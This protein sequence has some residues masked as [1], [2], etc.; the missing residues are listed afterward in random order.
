M[1]TRRI[2]IDAQSGDFGAKVIIRGVIE[3]Q[4]CAAYPFIA[5]LCGDS[6]EI[7]RV[8]DELEGEFSFDRSKYIVEHCTEKISSLENRSRVWRTHSNSSIIRCITLQKERVVDASVS[9]GDS[10][11]LIGA[12]QFLLGRSENVK[13]PAL[14]ALIPTA[15]KKPVLLLDVGANLNCRAEHLVSFASMGS[16]YMKR[17]FDLKAPAVSLLNIGKESSKGPVCIQDAAK[18]LLQH[19][20]VNYEGYI[21]GNRVLSGDADVVVCD[22]FSGNVLLKASESFYS[23]TASVLKQDPE[24]L[25]KLVRKMEALNP[26]N[27]GAV[28]F[29]GIKGT[30]LKA[31]GGSSSQA[32]RNA[33]LTALKTVESDNA[34]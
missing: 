14:A 30:V 34:H 23:L 24:L 15:G 26:E 25:G 17:L 7:C 12:A 19:R 11:I 9:A 6:G 3:A 18:I 27:Y 2:S 32:F 10:G 29:L 16:S 21:E 28:P 20:S 8:L 13:R 4:C 1:S 22:G 31:H 5:H 33:V